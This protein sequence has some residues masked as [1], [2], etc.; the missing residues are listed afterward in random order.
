VTVVWCPCFAG[1]S[2]FVVTILQMANLEPFRSP[3][4]RARF[5][6]RYDAVMTLWPVGFSDEVVVTSFGSTHVVLSGAEDAPPLVL[7]HGAA[8]TAAAWMP[9]IAALSRSYRCF[10]IDTITDGNKS[11]ATK[12]VNGAPDFVM[13]LREVFS[14]LGIGNARVGGLS[15]G[16]WLAALLAVHAPDLVNRLVLICPAGTFT[17]LTAGFMVRVLTASLLRSKTLVDRAIQWMS[18]TPDAASDP[19]LTLVGANL[20][21]CRTLRAELPQP[22]KLADEE[23]RRITVPTTVVIGDHEILYRGGAQAALAR[24][25]TLIPDVR[26][27]LVPNA[28]HV[29][30]L[31]APEVVIKALLAS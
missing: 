10:C 7:L 20:L 26:T 30:T 28:G 1:S 15:Y 3:T 19:V 8:T 29:L 6:E 11:V 17:P 13:W 25:R 18:T 14:A 21:T 22:V 24:A 31:D 9:A 23:L 2:G 5:I 4:D 16:G 27:E 12:R